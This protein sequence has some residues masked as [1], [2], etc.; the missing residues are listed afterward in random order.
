MINYLSL[1]TKST[2]SFIQLFLHYFHLDLKKLRRYAYTDIPKPNFDE[3]RRKSVSDPE[4]PAIK[5]ADDRKALSCIASFTGGV[6]GL[7]AFKAHMLHYIF[8]MSPSRDVLSEAQLEVKLSD[9]P[10]G[11]VSVVKWRG[12]PVFVYHRTQSIIEQ[13]R[14]VSLSELRDPETDD[15]R[16]KKPEWL[17]VVAICTHLGCV[18]IP[19]AGV[20]PGGFFCTCHGSH[21]DA[22]GRARKGPAPTNLEIPEY[23]F[24]SDDSIIIG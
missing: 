14:A 23:K 6:A 17:I 12:K 11:K 21:F 2:K 22:A 10:E 16:V 9:I 5:S 24:I 3:Y 19:N 8:F 15:D 13:E 4:T 7:Y 20:I 18:P 1:I